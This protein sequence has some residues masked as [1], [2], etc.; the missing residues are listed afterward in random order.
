MSMSPDTIT[1]VKIRRARI[2]LA[3]DD[4]RMVANI[5]KLLQSDFEVVGAV[6]DGRSLVDAAL[7]WRPDIIVSDIAMPKLN[8]IDAARQIIDCL[9]D[10]KFIFLTMHSGQQYR[11]EAHRVGAVAYILKTSAR[12]ELNQAVHD[13]IETPPGQARA[14]NT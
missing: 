11:A 4:Q 9:P 12:E 8:G 10:I 6:S 7:E 2:L 14:D 1:V 5:S 13:A 3:D